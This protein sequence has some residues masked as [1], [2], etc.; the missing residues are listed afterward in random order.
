MGLFKKLAEKLNERIDKD[1]TAAG[2]P[3]VIFDAFEEEYLG[4]AKEK[5][6]VSS[7]FE[8]L[9]DK[10]T[11]PVMGGLA[12]SIVGL[13]VGIVAAPVAVGLLAGG[14]FTAIAAQVLKQ[15]IG[16]TSER[17]LRKDYETGALAER[18]AKENVTSQ[19][20]QTNP[21]AI[22]LNAQN[23]VAKGFNTVAENNNQS[24]QA[25]AQ[26]IKKI[27]KIYLKHQ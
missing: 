24:N 18:Y 13:G 12:L 14:A 2:V 10:A 20:L 21:V 11:F 15:D 4:R 16:D 26:E 17:L 23:T 3:K 8:K 1:Y 9:F 19:G 27:K 22:L 5:M 7:F 6:P 25:Q